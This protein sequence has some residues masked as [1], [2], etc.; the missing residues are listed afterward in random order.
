MP[1]EKELTPVEEGHQFMTQI[2]E[3]KSIEDIWLNG[4]IVCCMYRKSFGE[5]LKCRES[6]EVLKDQQCRL[7]SLFWI[8][9]FSYF[10]HVCSKCI[11]SDW[12]QLDL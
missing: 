5:N 3:I 4:F 12:P 2:E 8:F 11:V 7:A 1:V 10:F 9:F 6:L